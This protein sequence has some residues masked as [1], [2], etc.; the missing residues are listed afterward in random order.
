MNSKKAKSFFA[1]SAAE[2][3]AFV[4]RVES[5]IPHGKLRPL[6]K[7]DRG[8][9]EKARRG[10]GRP[11]KPAKDKAVPIRVTF[12]PRLLAEIDACAQQRGVSRAEFLAEGA[13]LA[14]SH[15]KR[16]A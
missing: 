14:L 15:R 13:K 4:Q 2:K 3:E 8:M 10:P 1:M 9:W 5:G 6:S 11:R 16:S 12:E 7:G